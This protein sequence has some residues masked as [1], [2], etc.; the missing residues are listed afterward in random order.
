MVSSEAKGIARTVLFALATFSDASG[1]AHPAVQTLAILA[2]CSER[3]VQKALRQLTAAGEIV[4]LRKGG[5]RN[6]PTVYQITLHPCSPFQLGKKVKTLKGVL[7]QEGGRRATEERV[8]PCSPEGI[9]EHGTGSADSSLYTEE[10]EEVLDLYRAKLVSLDCGWL[11]VDRFT[12]E[13]VKAI[14]TRSSIEE[15]EELFDEMREDSELWPDRKTIVRLA[16]DNLS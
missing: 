5:G 3:A 4:V 10:E 6:R 15:W 8:N 7:N 1:Y 12:E 9:K 11:D 14:A 2:R 16:W 13:V